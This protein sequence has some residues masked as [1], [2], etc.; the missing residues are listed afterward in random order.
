MSGA[1]FCFTIVLPIVIR[2]LRVTPS[3]CVEVGGLFGSEREH[4][5]LRL[6]R[7][8]VNGSVF[9][10]SRS[11]LCTKC[12]MRPRLIEACG[13]RANFEKIVLS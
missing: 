1:G 2:K 12:A 5:A 4:Q 9:S 7:T 6:L 11:N 8:H 3:N 13:L 10:R